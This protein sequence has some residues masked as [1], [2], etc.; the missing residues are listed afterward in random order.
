MKKSAIISP[1]G[2]YRYRL[3]RWWGMYGAPLVFCMLNPST[4]DAEKDD[5]TIRRCIGFAQREDCPGL[6]VVNIFA[7]RATNPKELRE[8]SEAGVDV[9]GPEN[10]KH[11]YDVANQ[12]GKVVCAWGSAPIT[13]DMEWFSWRDFRTFGAKVYHLGRTKTGQP[14]HPL[15]VKKDQPLIEL[16]AS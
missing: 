12:Y 7:Y 9:R 4:A 2:L 14:R 13:E 6:V 10:E 16:K 15:Y 8:K 11:L 5:P 3:E 1:D